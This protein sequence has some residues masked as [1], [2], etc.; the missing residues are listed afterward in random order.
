MNTKVLL[1]IFSFALLLLCS[2]D[3]Y[4]TDGDKNNSSDTEEYQYYPGKYRGPKNKKITRRASTGSGF[5]GYHQQGYS[6]LSGSVTSG[7]EY[8]QMAG[9]K[10]SYDYQMTQKISIGVQGNIYFLESSLTKNGAYAIAIRGNYHFLDRSRKQKV[11]ID[12]YAGITLGDEF[13]E[14]GRIADINEIG[15]EQRT[16]LFFGVHLGLRYKF[17]NRWIVYGEFGKKT[18]GIGVGMMF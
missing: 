17:A 15:Q 18:S 8:G 11:P 9:I 6:I 4:A 5:S 12:L 14:Y 13:A 2:P 3:S 7:L 16:N 1:C 10:G